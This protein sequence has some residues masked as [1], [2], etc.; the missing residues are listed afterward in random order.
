MKYFTIQELSD[1]DTAVRMNI[2]NEP[3]KDAVENM[4]RLIDVVLDPAREL[5]GVPIRVN[6]GYRSKMLNEEVGGV[7]QSYHL[8]GRAADITAGS[9]SANRRLFAILRKLPHKE[10]IWEKGGIWIH[11]AL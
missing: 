3:D 7:K 11:V 5:L 2:D 1:S 10:L 8:S 6:S 4:R 9:V